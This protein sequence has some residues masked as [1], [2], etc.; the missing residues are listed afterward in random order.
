MPFNSLIGEIFALAPWFSSWSEVFEFFP[1]LLRALWNAN[2]LN[3]SRGNRAPASYFRGSR[4]LILGHVRGIHRRRSLHSRDVHLGI[5][6]VTDKSSRLIHRGLR[7]GTFGVRSIP[8]R[9]VFMQG[10]KTMRA[11]QIRKSG[12]AIHKLSGGK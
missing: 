10:A 5:T 11:T 8:N 4:P 9:T 7:R 2:A 12:S 3:R 6:T 1:S